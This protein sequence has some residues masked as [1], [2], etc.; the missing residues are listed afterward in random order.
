M[1]HSFEN[2]KQHLLDIEAIDYFFAEK[3][4][5]KYLSQDSDNH[6]VSQLF[7]V[8]LALQYYLRQGHTCLPLN[9]IA[10]TVLWQDQDNLETTGFKFASL[11]VLSSALDTLDIEN[12]ENSVLVLENQSLYLRR[13]WQF[14]ND[15]AHCLL[16]KMQ[17][18]CL[19]ASENASEI[20][21]LKKT[22]KQLFPT[23][24]QNDEIDWQ[25]VAVSNAI[26][27]NLNI[28]CG[29]PGTGK[30]YTV[31]RLLVML[32]AAHRLKGAD[33][34]LNIQM[35][36]PTGKA[37]QRL[38]ES[39][40]GAKMQLL[41]Q[42][43]DFSLL[44]SIPEE[45]KTLHRLLGYR[46]RSLDYRFNENNPLDCDVLLVDEVSMIDI[47]M[48]SRV[49]RALNPDA[50]L[51]LLGDADQLPSVETGN[52]IADLANKNHQGYDQA[53]AQQ[54][55]QIS[56]QSVP[57]NNASSTCNHSHITF[58]LKTH[59]FKGE[60]ARLA[61][62]VINRQANTSWQLLESYTFVPTSSAD[63]IKFAGEIN[64]F[65]PTIKDACLLSACQN[66]Y[67]KIAR[68]LEVE[69]AFAIL[70]A[71]RILCATRAGSL[72]VEQVNLIIEQQLARNNA[73][74]RIGRHYHGRPIMVVEN[75]YRSGLFNG[76]VGIV[77]SDTQGRLQAC[78]ENANGIKK[79]SLARL[80]KV[81]TVYA[82]TIH[83]TQGSEFS[84]V[85]LMLPEQDNKILS[86]ELIYT[87]ITRAKKQVSILA[88]KHVWY[89]ALNKKLPRHSGLAMKLAKII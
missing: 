33:V 77:W 88:A 24:Q 59:R 23:A 39:I 62:A 75:D 14:E 84:H 31:A 64:H 12:N 54:I 28:I 2:C 22:I 6:R 4:T 67:K 18:K 40:V 42:N 58:L 48:M 89:Q 86:P 19:N 81:E 52:L 79:V 8:F 1:Y 20:E 50:C 65:M 69:S 46:P 66:Y 73:A 45:A 82:M 13:Y 83:K 16:Q 36:A 11:A 29:G 34:Q 3:I 15:V 17:H 76:D 78:F 27:R 71:F 57:V 51:I 60:I 38:T 80:P 26:G 7:H 9:D 47:A 25:Q 10:E 72:G 5:E 56:G 63:V 37:A 70:N 32:Q 21:N 68:C 35:A 49:L 87:G 41:S 74:I 55:Q 85:L 44:T 30:T 43:V 61:K 53:S